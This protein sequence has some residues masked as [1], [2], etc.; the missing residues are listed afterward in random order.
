[1]SARDPKLG[2]PAVLGNYV[3]GVSVVTDQGDALGDSVEGQ[4]DDAT[5]ERFWTIAKDV[6]ERLASPETE[7][8][9][10]E[11]WGLMKFIPKSQSN[12]TDLP[13]TSTPT[14]WESFFSTP[15]KR[16]RYSSS[17]Q[18]SNLGRSPTFPSIVK[19]V[20]WA[21]P[22]AAFGAQAVELDVVG[23][24]D[25]SVWL[26]FNWRDGRKVNERNVRAIMASFE[27]VLECIAR[28]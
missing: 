14:G 21:H 20:V 27:T 1:M 11:T 23:N 5:K 2:H 4:D 28:V 12:S 24:E 13:P 22:A 19:D 8:A 25:G 7:K 26:A 15:N 3:L 10:R 6:A 16:Q 9:G 18:F 17:F